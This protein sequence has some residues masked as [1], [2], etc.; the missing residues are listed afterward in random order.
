MKWLNFFIDRPVTACV[1]N[2]MM[3]ICG[4]LALNGL[5]VDEYPH[6]IVP[7]LS[8]E[9]SY[10][11]ASALAIEK[12]VTG[13]IEDALAVVEG[14]ESL[15]SESQ[16]GESKVRL[17]FKAGVSMDR[18]LI[19]VNEQLSRIKSRLPEDAGTPK[20]TRGGDRGEA[21]FYLS[22][23]SNSLSGAALRHYTNTHIKSHFQGID[24]AAQVQVW[25][26]EYAMNIELDKLALFDQKISPEQ[27]THI[28]KKNELLLQ[29][30]NLGSNE[31]I[32]LDIVAKNARDYEQLVIG[33]NAEV[34]VLLQDVASV[35][36]IE[37]SRQFRLRVNGQNAIMLAISKA[38]DG[39]ILKVTDAIRN[40][41]PKVNEE[42]KGVAE[43]SIEADKSL[44]VRESLKTIYKT[45]IESCILV[46]LIIFLFLRHIRA[47][48]V[49][50]ITIP[51]SL[52]ANFF[53]LKIFGLSINIITLLAMVLAVGLVVDDAIVVLENI[54]RF[55]EKGLSAK[56][57]A[58]KGSEEI[59]FAIIAMT[60]TLI[61]VFIPLAFVSDITGVIL[62]EFAI[63]LACAVFF[64]GI[65][66]LT[67]S[68]LMCAYLLKNMP[69][70]NKLSLS[71]EKIIKQIERAYNKYLDKIFNFRK[72]IYISLAFIL[73][74][75][76]FLNT[77][78]SSDL[79]P[80]ED[81]GL[82][83]AF[84]PQVPGFDLDDLEPYQALAEQIFIDQPEVERT[85]TFAFS[86]G[87]QIVSILKPWAQRK[88]HA[89]KIVE[90]IRA[91][92]SDIPT[93]SIEPWSD[94]IGLS[95]LRDES[96]QNS[97]VAVAIKSAKSYEDIAV[98]AQN[99]VDAIKKDDFLKDARSDLN[100]NQKTFSV[101]ILREP[102]A[103][104]G[105]DQKSLSIALQTF[106][107]RMRPSEF[108]LEGQRY[109]VFLGSNS[110]TEDLSMIY[111]STAQGDQ[112]PMATVAKVKRDVQAPVLRHL[113]QMRNAT[114]LANLGPHT[115]L[116]EAK[117]YLDKII[118]Q[119]VPSDMAVS[120]EG[121]LA[122]QEKTSKT[123]FM[124][125]LAGLIFIFAVMAIQFEGILDPLIIL[126]TVPLASVGGIFML[127]ITNSGTN[128]YTQIGMLTLIGLITKHGILLTEFV[129]HHRHQGVELKKAIFE[130][131]RWRF[132]PIIMTTAAMI[133]GATPL[134]ITSGAGSEARASIGLV[135]VGG[136]IF[137]TLL[138]L[139]VLPTVIFSAYS[140][141]EKIRTKNI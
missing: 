92:S 46:L 81:R 107:D 118:K 111:V 110:P 51:I 5:L 96:G 52:I 42:I 94:N 72:F 35:A 106:A 37:D 137:G 19:Q 33:S 141:R 36:L 30:G 59:G 34:P 2:I 78:L 22:V 21:V 7:R 61:S 97:G 6:V 18:A 116:K 38:N 1:I 140:L 27:I 60:L 67:L 15:S 93:I 139:F 126:V 112:V 69:S 105:I 130:A 29:A 76:L 71:I 104:L 50:L 86:D 43:I 100:L 99:L 133:L 16:N 84:I 134:I 56:E 108:K 90:R 26:P 80:K 28:L 136:M 79:L 91:L 66:A 89:E 3:V 109:N 75:G 11:N 113:N 73:A 98:V 10:R 31:P 25:G 53:A 13:P 24:G 135:I 70:E 87:V 20:L 132:R 115:S 114:V 129:A 63:T 83:G 122:M 138:T 47:T 17:S 14:L 49:P 102:L 57:S 54:F 120:F 9:T 128:L 103:A 127:Y 62:R 41:I 58:R 85:L 123:F 39:N 44:F 119:H 64:S 12:E 82:I 68:P 124:L 45:I 65:V 101:E 55:K 125:F 131:A 74:L 8:V 77:R 121:A 4:L 95:A 88:V 23:K 48:L 117:I 40:I 32:N